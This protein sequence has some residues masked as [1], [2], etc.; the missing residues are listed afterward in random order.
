MVGELLFRASRLSSRDLII[1][2]FEHEL[3]K[4]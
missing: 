3:N 2:T 1:F 4:N